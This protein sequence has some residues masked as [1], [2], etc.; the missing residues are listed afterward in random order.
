MRPAGAL[1]C[2]AVAE[3][4]KGKLGLLARGI[5]GKLTLLDGKTGKPR[6]IVTD[7]EK[8]AKLRTRDD[9]KKMCFERYVPFEQKAE[10]RAE[11]VAGQPQCPERLFCWPCRSFEQAP[12][13][14]GLS[15]IKAKTLA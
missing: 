10:G 6:C 3:E 2:A 9:C 15:P 11:V 13:Q 8:A 12:A 14:P 1:T 7:I 4:L 5:T